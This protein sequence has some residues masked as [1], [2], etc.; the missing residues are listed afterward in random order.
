VLSTG[1]VAAQT[2]YGVLPWAIAAFLLR[3]YGAENLAPHPRPV[4]GDR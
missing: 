3:R 1:S 2:V 4:A